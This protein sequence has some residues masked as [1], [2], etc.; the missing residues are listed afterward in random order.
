[1]GA[2]P[3]RP[4]ELDGWDNTTFRLG[5][6]MA[7]HWPTVRYTPSKSTRNNAGCRCSHRNSRSRSGPLGRG[8]PTSTLRR[9]WSVYRLDRRRAAARRPHRRPGRAR[10]RPRW[11]PRSPLRVRRRPARRPALTPSSVAA[12]SPCGT[13]TSRPTCTRC[14]T[15]WTSWPHRR[16]GRRRSPPSTRCHQSGCTATSRA[17]T[18]SSAMAGWRR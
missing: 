15:R 6:T 11:V 14:A 10:R 16:C 5:D 2:L 3:V 9:P 17:P 4:V 13:T 8:Q 7:V 1:M 12:R 18:C